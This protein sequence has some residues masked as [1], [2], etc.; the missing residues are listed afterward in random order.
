MVGV[1]FLAAGLLAYA[2]SFSG[3]FLLD[4]VHAIVENS[5]I[6]RPGSL[7][8]FFSTS[9]RP[10]VDL[11]FALNHALG[12]LDPFGY[13]AV[14]L[15]IHWIAAWIL[16]GILHRMLLSSR[17]QGRYRATA[18]GCSTVAALW[19]ML[20]PLQ[21][22]SVTY[23]V[24]RSE[25]L[26]GL[27]F[28]LTLYAA[29]RAVE[30]SGGSPPSRGSSGQRR[31]G[32]GWW[33]VSLASCALGT[34]SKASM[35]IVPLVVL[36]YD[37]LFLASSMGEIWRKRKSYYLGLS[38]CTWGLLPL[39]LQ[40]G[41]GEV[42]T[43]GFRLKD[44]TPMEYLVT[45]PGVILHY[46]RLV[47][48]PDILILDYDWP[49]AQ[50]A[51]EVWPPALVLAV[52]MAAMLRWI[53]R[54]PE[55]GFWGAWFFLT[56]SPTS[57]FVPIKDLAFE[58]RM[59]LPL[60]GI[61]A[62]AVLWGVSWSERLLRPH[63]LRAAVLAGLGVTVAAAFGIRTALRNRD[64]RS[65][66]DMWSDVMAKR[67]HN[68][69]A[70]TNLL[71]RYERTLL[72]QGGNANALNHL[73]A[74]GERLGRLDMV[75]EVLER[76][77]REEKGV[78][79]VSARLNLADLDI[80]TAR[81]TEAE[82]WLRPIGMDGVKDLSQRRR[83]VLAWGRICIHRGQLLEAEAKVRE[84]LKELPRDVELLN[85]L[86]VVLRHQGRLKEALAVLEQALALYPEAPSLWMNL[87]NIYR[88]MKLEEKAQQAYRKQGNRI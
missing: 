55:I 36:L 19:W 48:W 12:G 76:A 54:R 57:S 70:L 83:L 23:I 29:I 66:L 71:T 87:S 88:D 41:T 35:A 33:S 72:F 11:S 5:L 7:W 84:A 34:A 61:L 80:A 42:P 39:L 67:P 24:Q 20:H 75:R 38:A 85:M 21:T 56:L 62:V 9:I 8:A 32:R 86:G 31:R 22:E 10:V 46:L 82:R 44:V 26:M 78:P 25:L 65:E 43:A 64:Y 58:H 49:V 27:F 15:V 79:N 81:F 69:R 47:F 53:R 45:Q 14:N 68:T 4:D 18:F 74:A 40:A 50:S 77:V 37:R 2:N 51:V 6:R 28:L 60:A 30:S 59:Y 13:H 52:L 17:L 63:R 16:W 73:G 3:V 1:G